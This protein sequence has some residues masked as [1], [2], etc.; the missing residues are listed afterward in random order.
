[1]SPAKFSVEQ[2][3]LSNLLFAVFVLAGLGVYRL[4]PVDVYP[5]ISLDEAW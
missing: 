5:D 1:M 3:V 4:L 2:A